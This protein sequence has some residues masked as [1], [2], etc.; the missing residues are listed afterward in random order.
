MGNDKSTTTTATTTWGDEIVQAIWRPTVVIVGIG[1]PLVYLVRS[2][3]IGHRFPTA[4]HIPPEVFGRQQKIRGRVVSVGDSDNFR[5]YHTPGWGWGWARKV[6]VSRKGIY[7]SCVIS[8]T[9]FILV[10]TRTQEPNN[11]SA[12]G[13]D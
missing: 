7:H 11:R 3:V 4:A 8:Y 12:A 2:K 13:W 5:L 9:I 10:H 1:I 6:P